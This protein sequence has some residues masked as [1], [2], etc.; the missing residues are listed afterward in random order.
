MENLKSRFS[1]LGIL[2]C[3]S[4]GLGC[5]DLTTNTTTPPAAA[6][7]SSPAPTPS[8]AITDPNQSTGNTVVVLGASFTDPIGS[9]SLV[10]VNPPRLATTN[11]QTTHSDASVR[12][13]GNRLYVVNKLGQDNIQIVDPAKNFSVVLQCSVGKGTNPQ[14]IMVVSPTK[15]YVTLYQPE[16]NSSSILTV[17][18]LLIVDPSATSCNSFITRVIDLTPL[19]AADGEPLARASEM[20]L[21]GKKLFVALQDLPKNLAMAPNQAGKIAVIDTDTDIISSSIPLSGRDPIAM[22]YSS[23]SGLIY[24][25]DADYFDLTSSF[26]GIEVVDPTNLKSLGLMIDDFTLG[27]APGDIESSGSKGYVTVGVLDSRSGKYTTKV[28]SFNLDPTIAPNLSDVYKG[29][30]YI[31]DMAIDPNGKLVIGDRD[32]LINGLLFIDTQTGNV[33]D[34]PI[35]TGPS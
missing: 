12:S 4:L 25:A 31:Q 29:Q 6:P 34:G 15:A 14:Q 19:A 22:T 17:D 23:S 13:F 9:L 11:V 10:P 20:V 1:F 26:G 21:I 5:S 18:D 7:S 3:T 28:T 24:V 16:D 32:P 8:T 30:G 33:V 35:S 27:G 2:L